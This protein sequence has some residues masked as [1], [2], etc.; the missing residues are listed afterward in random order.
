MDTETYINN[1]KTYLLRLGYAESTIHHNG[2]HLKQFLAHLQ[3][4]NIQ[5]LKEVNP[6][7]I[8]VYN[9]YLHGLKSRIT[10]MGLSGHTIQGKINVIKQFSQFLELTEQIKL[11]TTEVEIIPSIKQHKT[12]ITQSQIKQLYNETDDSVNGL[13]ERTILGLYYGCGL[14]YG[15]GTRLELHHIDYKKEL[16]YVSPSKNYKSRYV[17]VNNGVL[18]DFKDYET[19]ARNCFKVKGNEFLSGSKGNQALNKTLQNLCDKAGIPNRL[20]L[21]G[22]RH[23]IATHLLQQQMPLEQIAQFL[24]HTTLMATQVYTHIVNELNETP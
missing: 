23:S 4:Q 3:K 22:L 15:E 5:D 20:C 21:H 18:K 6:T 11:L 1:Y 16:L 10:N 12:I 8:I 17:P 19:Y 7:N 24:G 2:N 14:R 13:R 9:D